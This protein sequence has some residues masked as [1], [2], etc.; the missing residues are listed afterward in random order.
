MLVTLRGYGLKNQLAV[1][2][3]LASRPGILFVPFS[4]NFNLVTITIRDCFGFALLH[5]FVISPESLTPF[6]KP[7]QIRDLSFAFPAL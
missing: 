4:I 7:I 1:P 5:F 2:A 3:H 6:F